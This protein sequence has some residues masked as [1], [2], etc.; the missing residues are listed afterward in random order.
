MYRWSIMGMMNKY[1]MIYFVY[2][3]FILKSNVYVRVMEVLD[4]VEKDDIEMIANFCLIYKKKGIYLWGDSK[5]GK[6][7]TVLCMIKGIYF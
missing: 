5:I 6:F 1:R 3:E 4:L 2:W 7:T